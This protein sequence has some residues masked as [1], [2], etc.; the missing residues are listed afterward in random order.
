MKNAILGLI[1]LF[2]SHLFAASVKFSWTPP[3]AQTGV[4]ITHFNIYQVSTSGS[5]T[6]NGPATYSTPTVAAGSTDTSFTAASVAPG[7]Y[8]AEVTAAGTVNG[9][10]K[11]SAL[12]NEVTYVVPAAVIIMGVPVQQPVQVITQ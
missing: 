10:S 9:V 6:T 3:S 12:S 5:E 2:S 8:F 7:V 1:L 11:E 4:V